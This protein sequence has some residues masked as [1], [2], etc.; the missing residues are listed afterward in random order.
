MISPIRVNNNV[1]PLAVILAAILV[2]RTHS[3][4]HN[5]RV[6]LVMRYWQG[7]VPQLAPHKRLGTLRRLVTRRYERQ[8][9]ARSTT[10]Y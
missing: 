10:I 8:P 5:H 6:F 9:S 2:Y 4:Y 7:V 3:Y 1:T